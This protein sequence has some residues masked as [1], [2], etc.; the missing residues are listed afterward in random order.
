MMADTIRGRIMIAEHVD[1]K[2]LSQMEQWL[3]KD[4]L[5]RWGTSRQVFLQN[6]LDELKIIVAESQ[7]DY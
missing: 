3:L 7:R 2:Y 6:A 5:K 1:M 4:W